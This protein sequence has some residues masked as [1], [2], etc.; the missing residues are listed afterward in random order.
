MIQLISLILIMT[1][2][3]CAIRHGRKKGYPY[4]GDDTINKDDDNV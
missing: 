2:I 1:I 4:L 3:I